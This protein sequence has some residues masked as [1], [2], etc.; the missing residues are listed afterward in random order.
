MSCKIHVLFTRISDIPKH[1]NVLIVIHNMT[2]NYYGIIGVLPCV[3]IYVH[4]KLKAQRMMMSSRYVTRYATQRSEF[5]KLCYRYLGKI[6]VD[7]N[8]TAPSYENIRTGLIVY[9]ILFRFAAYFCNGNT[10]LCLWLDVLLFASAKNSGK[11][12]SFRNLTAALHICIRSKKYENG[13]H[14]SS[15]M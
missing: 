3:N 2:V 12:M 6:V 11:F 14:Y 13:Q 7:H 4:L 15:L 10:K 1:M 5:E 9:N 8:H